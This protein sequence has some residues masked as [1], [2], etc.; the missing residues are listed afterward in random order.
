MALDG[1]IFGFVLT[2][3]NDVPIM[4]HTGIILQWND[5][6]PWSSIIGHYGIGS[7]GKVYIHHMADMIDHID[8]DR[9]L[10]NPFV[11]AR[12]Q[13]APYEEHD[14]ELYPGVELLEYEHTHPVYNIWTS[15][16]Q[17]FVAHFVPHPLFLESDIHSYIPGLVDGILNNA[18]HGKKTAPLLNKMIGNYSIWRSRGIC[19]WDRSLDM[20]IS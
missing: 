1:A 5:I 18:I 20:I 11:Y 9:I 6:D 17:H 2:G 10:I 16:C 12:F 3:N 7:T 13:H 19:R 15:N 14:G 8:G 4:H